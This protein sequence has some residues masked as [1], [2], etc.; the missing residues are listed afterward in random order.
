MRI[1]RAAASPAE[2]IGGPLRLRTVKGRP[3][4]PKNKRATVIWAP[5]CPHKLS[6]YLPRHHDVANTS[7][8]RDENPRSTKGWHLEGE[9]KP[10]G[11]T[12]RLV[13]AYLEVAFLPDVAVYSQAM[14]S[15]KSARFW[16]AQVIGE[17]DVVQV[18]QGILR[19]PQAGAGA[20][21]CFVPPRV[22]ISAPRKAAEF[23]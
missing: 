22:V 10:K 1:S 2:R 14:D 15:K 3:D 5:V 19:R 8:A 6:K 11:P 7:L 12:D 16:R 18:L 9:G 13:R 23:D 20:G 21:E 4:A 17:R